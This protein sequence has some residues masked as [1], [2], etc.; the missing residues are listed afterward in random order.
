MR[1]FRALERTVVAS[2]GQQ[3][4]ASRSGSVGHQAIETNDMALVLG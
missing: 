3:L 2:S 1:R 4:T